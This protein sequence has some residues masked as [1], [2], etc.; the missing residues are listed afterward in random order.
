METEK[1]LRLCR[2]VVSLTK[3]IDNKNQRLCE[4]EH[5][6]NQR[7]LDMEHKYNDSSSTLSRLVLD[8]TREIDI[9]D[10]MFSIME[11]KYNEVSATISG[12]IE[13]KKRLHEAYSEE[14]RQMN[15]MRLQNT[16]LEHELEYLKGELE[17]DAKEQEKC[18]A[19]IELEQRKLIVEKEKYK[20]ASEE[21]LIFEKIVI[22]CHFGFSHCI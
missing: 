11:H 16:K 8:L 12:L 22:N 20:G 13:D 15:L 4:M 14:L 9:K 19:Q 1:L 18:S 7:L 10:Q 21:G 6:C 2:S 5:K 3:E 17:N